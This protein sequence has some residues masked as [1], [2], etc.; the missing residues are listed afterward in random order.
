MARNSYQYETSPRKLEPEYV[1]VKRRKTK[2]NYERQN[3]K[4]KNVENK[5]VVETSST[6]KLK[7]VRQVAIVLLLFTILLAISYR[8]SL[9][10]E[11]FSEIKTL[12]NDLAVVKKENGQITKDIEENLN[13]DKIEQIAT[14]E[15]G[16]Q[17][18]TK[19]QTIE[20]SIEK[21]DYIETATQEIDDEEDETIFEKIIN[22]IF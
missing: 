2:S 5:K 11:Q 20:I 19:D 3:V 4:T 9:I 16:M 22:S 10:N 8:N 15:L 7:K 18:K 21:S 1:P 14:E 13:K 6:Q 17:K 12:K